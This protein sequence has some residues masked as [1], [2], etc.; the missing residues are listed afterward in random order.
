ME[1][2]LQNNNRFYLRASNSPAT[3]ALMLS[4]KVEQQWRQQKKWLGS[5]LPMQK[6]STLTGNS[7]ALLGSMVD[8]RDVVPGGRASSHSIWARAA[9]AAGA[10]RKQRRYTQRMRS[11]ALRGKALS[12]ACTPR[13]RGDFGAAATVEI[14]GHASPT[15]LCYVYSV[16]A[17]T[18]WSFSRVCARCW[19]ALHHQT[20]WGCFEVDLILWM[21]RDRAIKYSFWSISYTDLFLWSKD[22]GTNWERHM[23]IAA[24]RFFCLLGWQYA[25]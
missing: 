11:Q 10:K 23:Q 15:H 19:G 20:W 21:R 24:I 9:A 18:A 14:A 25:W 6:L 8:E 7:T 4:F 22:V 17:K 1:Q 12:C 2:L 5:H 3:W 13:L 16:G